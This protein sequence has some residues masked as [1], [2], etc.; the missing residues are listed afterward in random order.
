MSRVRTFLLSDGVVL[1]VDGHAL[2]RQIAPPKKLDSNEPA[3]RVRALREWAREIETSA[4]QL[5]KELE[6]RAWPKR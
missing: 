1:L 6:E 2:C 5:E 3:D 4:E